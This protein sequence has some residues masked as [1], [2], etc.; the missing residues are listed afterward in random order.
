MLGRAALGAPLR[1][2]RAG[3]A[4]AA[5]RA[6]A[7]AS[8]SAAAPAAADGAA[9]AS[10]REPGAG[11]AAAGA[12]PAAVRRKRILSGV[13]PT[14]AIH[15]GNY[16][17]AIRNWVALQDEYG[18]P[19][20]WLWFVVLFVEFTMDVAVDKLNCCGRSNSRAPSPSRTASPRLNPL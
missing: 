1:A 20:R 17:G 7:S 13:Q 8:A 15:L 11:A 9:A 6:A 10:A 12:P 14:G 18:A 5:Q 3:G 2:L 19:G 4:A 16:L